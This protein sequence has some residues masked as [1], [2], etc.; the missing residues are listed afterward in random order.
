MSEKVIITGATGDIGS[1]VAKAFADAGYTL[2]LVGGKNIEK[3][4]LLKKQFAPAYAKCVDFCDSTEAEKVAAEAV[5]ALDGADIFI[6]C[7]GMSHIGLFQDLSAEKWS[8]IIDTNLS[9]AHIFTKEIIPYMV[10]KKYGRIIYISSV[11]GSVGASCEAAYSATKGGIDSLCRSLAKELA[12][13]GIAVNCIAPGYIETKMNSCFD[14][15]EKKDIFAEIPMGRPGE[16][17]E[18]AQ[19]VLGIAKLPIYLT[20]QVVKVDGGW[21]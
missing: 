14:E 12:P 17:A 6:H 13:S 1:E 15:E 5:T 8:E 3:L 20:G 7:A 10:R 9:S 19:S 11:W 21:T 16:P 2:A 4:E 18:L